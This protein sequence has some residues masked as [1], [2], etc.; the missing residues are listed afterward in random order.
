MAVFIKRCTQLK[1]ASLKPLA[2]HFS[3]LCGHLLLHRSGFL[4]ILA[5]HFLA[6]YSKEFDGKVKDISSGALQGSAYY[7]LDLQ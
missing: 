3:T 7:Q 5:R 2:V 1:T 6:K 4:P